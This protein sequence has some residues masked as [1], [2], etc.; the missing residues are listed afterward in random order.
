MDVKNVIKLK[1]HTTL[2]QRAFFKYMEFYSMEQDKSNAKPD[3][4]T[5]QQF[6]QSLRTIS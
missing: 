3:T 5:L 6:L 1:S 4:N 2:A